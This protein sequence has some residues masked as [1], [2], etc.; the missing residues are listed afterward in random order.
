MFEVL[1]Q[2][3]KALASGALDQAERS[4]WQL[5]ELDPTNAIAVAGLA[6]VSMER[7]D[8]RLA[9]TFADRA[10]AMDPEMVA[11]KRI[12]ET[13]NGGVAEAPGSEQ[14]DLPLLA[15]QR[16]EALGRRRAAA[17]EDEGRRR[18]SRRRQAGEA[19]Q[20][21]G[22]R[23]PQAAPRAPRRTAGGAARRPVARQR[24]RQRLRRRRRQRR[25]RGLRRPLAPRR[26]RRWAIEPTGTCCRR[27]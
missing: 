15:A 4:Y 3:D 17:A 9:R 16:L 2:A 25:L 10:L 20:G 14:P 8:H 24:R 18:A 21:G 19:G 22:G 26:I 13:L 1:L 5:I 7:G 12:L 11:A 6:R 23:S 27:I